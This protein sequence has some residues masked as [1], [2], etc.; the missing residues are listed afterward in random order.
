MA[1]WWPWWAVQEASVPCCWAPGVRWAAAEPPSCQRNVLLQ[2]Y[3]QPLCSKQIHFP[4]S[5]I[6]ICCYRLHQ[7]SP[8]EYCSSIGYTSVVVLEKML[9]NIQ[10]CAL[11]SF[12]FKLRPEWSSP[13]PDLRARNTAPESPPQG[14]LRPQARRQRYSSRSQRGSI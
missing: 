8:S 3:I 11:L 12:S 7:T 4:I 1:L 9:E 13:M 5:E 10:S 2:R 14:N 6:Q